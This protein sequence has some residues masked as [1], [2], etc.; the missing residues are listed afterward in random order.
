[1]L[2]PLKVLEAARD[3]IAAQEHQAKGSKVVTECLCRSM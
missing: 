3:E 1:M 2:S